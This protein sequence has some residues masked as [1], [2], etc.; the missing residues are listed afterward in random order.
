M[1]VDDAAFYNRET[2]ELE[3]VA[4]MRD[5]PDQYAL[6]VQIERRIANMEAKMESTEAVI[7]KVA[8]EVMPTIDELI[9]SPMLKMLGVGKKK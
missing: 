2:G 1:S 4:E 6:L 8:A 5:K 9:K 7:Q 3:T